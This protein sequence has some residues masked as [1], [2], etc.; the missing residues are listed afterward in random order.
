[1]KK[2]LKGFTLI[3]LLVVI[4]IIAI[5]STIV[6]IAL[7]PARQFAQARNTQRFSNVNAILNAV[8]QNLSDN[9]GIFTCGAGTIPTTPTDMSSA[10][11]YDIAPC[12]IP[13]Y[14][15]VMPVDPV[16]GSYTS[17]S[18]YDTG[19]KISRDPLTSRITVVA[20]STELGVTVSVT[21]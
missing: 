18:S 6:I 3:E 20:S 1:M 15:S 10:G 17:T 19:Y 2:S 8:G 4:G 7:N 5:L 21:R 12:I 9:N 14:I 11:G 13:T 16:I